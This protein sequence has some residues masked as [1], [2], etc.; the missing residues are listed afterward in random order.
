M[1]YSVEA[2]LNL[3]EQRLIELTDSEESVGVKDSDLI[4]LLHTKA[5]NKINAALYGKYTLDEDD[6]PPILTELE[7]DLWRYYLYA[8]RETVEIPKT[9]QDEYTAATALL[10]RYRTGEEL[11]AG[12]HTN[13]VTGP[14][15]S[16][17]SFSADSDD[18]MLGRAKDGLF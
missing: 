12:A 1:G 8:H 13:A 10:E 3:S 9:V 15:A 17:G 18:R 7:S 6:F 11:L 4:D 2:D 14:T 16:G 5:T